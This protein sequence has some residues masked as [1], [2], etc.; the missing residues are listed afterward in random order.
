MLKGGR[1]CFGQAGDTRNCVTLL[2]QYISAIGALRGSCSGTLV[3]LV[4][5]LFEVGIAERL[6]SLRRLSRLL[7][8]TLVSH[9]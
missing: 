6:K 7:W 5:L 2:P 4:R 1:A 8:R 3:L 9:T